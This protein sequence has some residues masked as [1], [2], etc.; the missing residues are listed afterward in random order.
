[1]AKKIIRE[2]PNE[3]IREK[4]KF[5]PSFRA[6]HHGEMSML[7]ARLKIMPWAKRNKVL[8]MLETDPQ[9][10]MEYILGLKE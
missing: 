8:K 7:E 4:A 6:M 10:A 5:A 2:H 1:M 9:K 3:E